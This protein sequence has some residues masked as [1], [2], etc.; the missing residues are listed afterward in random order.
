MPKAARRVEPRNAVVHIYDED[1][2]LGKT[3][4]LK[5]TKFGTV[6]HLRSLLG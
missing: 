4:I 3:L 5:P 2:P 6:A 1:P